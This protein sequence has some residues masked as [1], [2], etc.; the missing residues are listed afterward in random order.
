MYRK[1]KQLEVQEDLMIKPLINIS[2]RQA[3]MFAF[4]L[5]LYEFLTYIA[6]D[7]IMP[8]MIKVV[9]TFHGHESDIADSLTMYLLGG[10]SLQLI[11][12]PVSDRYG[13]R[14]VMLFGASLFLCCTVAIACS[15]SMSQF[16]A[17]RFFQGMGLC[18][19]GVVGYATLQEIFAEMDA[20]RLISVMA[21]VATIAPLLGPLFGALVIQSYSWRLIFVSIACIAL[22]SLWGLWKYMPEPVGEI[23]HD[24]EAIGRM[25]LSP[26]VIVMNYQVLGLNRKFMLGSLAMGLLQ[27]PCIVWIAL[28]PVILVKIANLSFFAYGVWQIPVFGACI[29]GNMLLHKMTHKNSAGHLVFVGSLIVAIGLFCMFLLPVLFGSHYIWLM[30]GTI[31]YFFGIGFAS[32]PLTRIILFSTDVMKG[33]ASALMSMISMCVQ[34]FGLM[35][36]N[37]LGSS[38]HY[39]ILSG[40]CLLIGFLFVISLYYCAGDK[41]VK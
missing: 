5:V 26:R 21:N 33:T 28:S 2:Q 30:P 3:M 19:I 12:G 40:Y 23:K 16:M 14:K 13:R 39:L 34:A 41:T 25:S 6:N 32:A 9:D 11:L 27:L 31:V 15:N 22:L 24:G 36:A 18:F 37:L 4:F 29:A 35:V 7:M 10:A 17:G 38:H 8:G 20:I 1:H